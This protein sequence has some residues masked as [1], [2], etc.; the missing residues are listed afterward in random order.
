MRCLL[1]QKLDPHLFIRVSFLST[2][3]S[4][5][6]GF[7]WKLILSGST[8]GSTGSRSGV[9]SLAPFE[10]L[11][12]SGDCTAAASFL[13]IGSVSGLLPLLP[14]SALPGSCSVTR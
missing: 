8:R 13:A 6:Y 5:E 10:R 3:Q 12:G 7:F 14:R 2:R 9:A 11:P 1:R 4:H